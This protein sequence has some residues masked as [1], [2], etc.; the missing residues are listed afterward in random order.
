VLIERHEQALLL[1][2]APNVSH[3][4]HLCGSFSRKFSK[5]SG[6]KKQTISSLAPSG[7]QLQLAGGPVAPPAVWPNRKRRIQC[8]WFGGASGPRAEKWIG[9]C[10]LAVCVA[11]CGQCWTHVG[12]ILLL[13]PIMRSLWALWAASSEPLE[14][15]K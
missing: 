12:P 15:P 5:L 14:A 2:T 3:R 1:A 4:A 10:V 8:K 11:V 13:A 9:A 7:S 6:G